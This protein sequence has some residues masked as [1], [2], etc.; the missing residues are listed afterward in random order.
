MLRDYKNHEGIL[1]KLHICISSIQQLSISQIKVYKLNINVDLQALD[2]NNKSIG[3]P[4][5]KLNTMSTNT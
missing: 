1:C 5:E 4:G 2:E 3:I